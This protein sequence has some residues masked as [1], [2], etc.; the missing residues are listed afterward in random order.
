MAQIAPVQGLVTGDFDGDGN[1]DIVA[2]QNSFAPMPFVGRLDG[3]VG[4]YLAGDGEGG[5][6]AVPARLS[7]L[8]ATGDAKALMRVDLNDD[9]MPDL[10][11]TRNNAKMMTLSSSG[12]RLSARSLG[13]TLTGGWTAGAKVT[14]VG[15]MIR[16][17]LKKYRLVRVISANPVRRYF[18]PWCLCGER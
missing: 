11:I 12:G 7:G 2:V 18:L 1:V 17:K 8:F 13:V 4:Q 6:T 5:F 14:L 3:G 15:R 10:V 9:G 16:G